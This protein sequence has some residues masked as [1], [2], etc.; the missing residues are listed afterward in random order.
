MSELLFGELLCFTGI[1]TEIYIVRKSP[2]HENRFILNFEGRN[3]NFIY[4]LTFI[5]FKLIEET[6]QPGL[7][8]KTISSRTNLYCEQD[9]R[10]RI[11]RGCLN[12]VKC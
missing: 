2:L 6:I 4:K 11:G 9:A 12:K 10:F 1:I 7:C 8:E 3:R 5:K